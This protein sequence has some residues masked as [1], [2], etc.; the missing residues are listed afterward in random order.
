MTNVEKRLDDLEE[1]IEYISV[2]VD[3]LV[4]ADRIRMEDHVSNA[5]IA[6]HRLRLSKVKDRVNITIPKSDLRQE[7]TKKLDELLGFVQNSCND[8]K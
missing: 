5:E 6:D 3:G 2:I 7:F 8:S 1:S 4:I